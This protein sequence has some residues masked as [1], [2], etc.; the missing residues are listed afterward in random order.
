MKRSIIVKVEWD[1]EAKVWVATSD[2]IGLVTEAETQDALEQ[3]ALQMISELLELEDE[4]YSDLPE[5]PVHF[6]AQRL[7]RVANPRF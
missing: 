3:K 7:G 4:A 2:D 5:I 1:E 6:M